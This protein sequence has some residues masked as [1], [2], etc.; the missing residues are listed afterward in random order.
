VDALA[1]DTVFSS[2]QALM[3]WDRRKQAERIVIFMQGGGEWY[4]FHALYGNT[5]QLAKGGNNNGF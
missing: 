1:S 3:F 4:K 2:M 5:L